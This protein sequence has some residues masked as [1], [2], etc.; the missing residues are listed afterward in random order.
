MTTGHIL[1]FE[2]EVWSVDSKERIR[3]IRERHRKLILEPRG[4]MEYALFDQ[5]EEEPMLEEEELAG[6]LAHVDPV[7]ED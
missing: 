6:K 2:T 5:W 4:R 7:N 3:L 1:S